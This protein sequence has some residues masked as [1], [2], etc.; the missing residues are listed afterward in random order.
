MLLILFCSSHIVHLILFIFLCSSYFVHLI[1]F[2]SYCSSYFVHLISFISYCSSY[3]VHLISFISLVPRPRHRSFVSKFGVG[4]S[5]HSLSSVAPIEEFSEV[6][7]LTMD[8]LHDAQI[9][10]RRL[11]DVNFFGAALH[12]AYA[13]EMESVEETRQKMEEREKR[14]EKRL[15]KITKERSETIVEKD[16]QET[17]EKERKA[18]RKTS[19]KDY[20]SQSTWDF[21]NIGSE[22]NPIDKNSAIIGPKMNSIDNNTS[23]FGPIRADQHK[24]KTQSS[25]SVNRD[26]SLIMENEDGP[27]SAKKKRLH[28]PSMI[29]SRSK[30]S[31]STPKPKIVFTSPKYRPANSAFARGK[32]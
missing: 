27:P 10:K 18:K 15:E 8:S 22:M 26:L 2:I 1:L 13:P 16:V 28:W 5:S 17:E 32:P 30:S 31:S 29:D 3:I 21:G 23:C 19:S 14:Y 24:E 9:A 7:H 12:V 11:D 25:T 4:V 6:P 20:S